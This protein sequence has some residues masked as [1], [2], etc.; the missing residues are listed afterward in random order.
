M[1][2]LGT[3]PSPG[4]R[5][6]ATA[7]LGFD[8]EETCIP[9][10][11]LC[12]ST[13]CASCFSNAS[14]NAIIYATSHGTM[15]T[16]SSCEASSWHLYVLYCGM[17]TSILVRVKASN[18]TIQNRRSASYKTHWRASF[19]R[20]SHSVCTACASFHIMQ[21]HPM[22]SGPLASSTASYDEAVCRSVGGGFH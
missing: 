4:Y 14:A 18:V 13:L 7:K 3:Q 20:M 17:G 10:V 22:F 1:R 2:I 21:Y 16:R 12:T 5:P 19:N 8:R 9:S 6:R 15:A 11:Q